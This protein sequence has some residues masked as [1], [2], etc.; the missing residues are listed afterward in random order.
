MLIEQKTV[1]SQS[2][3]LIGKRRIYLNTDHSGL[4]KFRGEDDE[5]FWLFLPEVKEIVERANTQHSTGMY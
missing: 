4:N 1:T 2:A 5:N 3:T